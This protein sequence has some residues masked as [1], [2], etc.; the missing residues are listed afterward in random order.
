[1]ADKMKQMFEAGRKRVKG[2]P[3]PAQTEC[4]RFLM[5]PVC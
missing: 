2:E 3:G 5:Y 1:M 4:W